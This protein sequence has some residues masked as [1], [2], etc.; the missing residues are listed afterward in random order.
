MMG[1]TR[2]NDEVNREIQTLVEHAKKNGA[3]AYEIMRVSLKV[4]HR[5]GERILAMHQ[6]ALDEYLASPESRTDKEGKL[7]RYQ[8]MVRTY[9]GCQAE[10]E[11]LL[12]M[13]TDIEKNIFPADWRVKPSWS[14]NYTFEG[15]LL[16]NLA[17]TAGIMVGVIRARY[18][19]QPLTPEQMRESILRGEEFLT[20]FIKEDEMST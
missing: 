19:G 6:N 9:T 5:W 15:Q 3:L 8:E 1:D 13:L 20:Q 11:G 2:T 14:T 10:L 17:R 12:Q 7:A 16:H 4:Q 18:G